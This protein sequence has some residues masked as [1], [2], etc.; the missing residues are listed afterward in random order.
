VFI[1]GSARDLASAR[2]LAASTVRASSAERL[3]TVRARWSALLTAVT[4]ATPDPLFDAM[5]NHWLVYQTVS[6]RLWARAGFYQAGGA[7]GFRDQLQDAAA[8]TWVAPT[9]LAAQIELAASRQF[10]EGD[11][12]HWWH[13]PDG[14]GVRTHCSDDRLWL[15][16]ACVRYLR[17][18][19][20]QSLLDR[21]V[22]FITGP[23]LR[24]DQ[25]DAYFVP[26]VSSEHSSIYEH[27]AR[28]IDC[29]LASGVHGLPLIGG[30]DWNDGMNRV[31]HLGRGESTWL[32]WFLLTVI[33]GFAPIARAR[34]DEARVVRWE[35]CA[36]GWHQTLEHS[37][38]DGRWYRR[39]FFDDGEPLGGESC[40]EAKIDLVAQAWA[41]LC[42]RAIP[43]R[44]RAAMIALDTRLV[45]VDAGLVRLLDPPFVSAQPSPGYIQAYPP[46]VREN[47]G[48]YTHAAVWAMMAQA[49]CAGVET[50]DRDRG[51]TVYRY[52]CYLSPAHRAAH[53]ARA[54]HYGL[55]P[56]VVAGDVCS[57]PPH[58]G[59]GGWSWYTGAAGWLHRA[60]IES[61]FG[62]DQQATT[63]RFTPCLPPGWKRAELTLR[64]DRQTLRF[65]LLRAAE[66]DAATEAGVPDA[67]LLLAGA[68]LAWAALTGAH[69]FVI[70][71]PALT[72]ASAQTLVTDH[73]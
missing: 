55:E 62:L 47:G 24:L 2:A 73:L 18:T 20:D 69:C 22:P 61:M 60:A 50:S 68:E 39:G 6:C 32:G 28:A 51:E 35:A 23:S 30:G 14:A 19:G 42:G 56:Y 29:S 26:L 65:I 67:T 25:E 15:P 45:D 31:G 54:M 37:A 1:L 7:T 52:F 43:E 13:Q 4:V 57:Q 8:L 12:Q 66:R 3:L 17:A 36:A 59:R 11:V 70:P 48:Q 33:D 38:W 34:G 72:T 41:V 63:L 71:L 16:Y 49:A 10:V 44:Q 58:V 21:S 9:L 46:G 27:A 64:R 5:V 40:R 53:P